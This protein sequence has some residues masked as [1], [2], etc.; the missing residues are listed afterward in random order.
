MHQN[1]KQASKHSGAGSLIASYPNVGSDCGFS[2]WTRVQPHSLSQ[3]SSFKR[4]L[5]KGLKERGVKA[6][7]GGVG[8]DSFT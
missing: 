5:S 1:P 3:L 7:A 8:E 6:C 2:L 4:I